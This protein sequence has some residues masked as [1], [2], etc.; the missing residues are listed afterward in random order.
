MGFKR[1]GERDKLLNLSEKGRVWAMKAEA[2]RRA[3]SGPGG[4]RET[5]EEGER[6]EAP[7]TAQR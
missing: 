1:E 7:R 3:R 4:R 6:K 2:R 5:G